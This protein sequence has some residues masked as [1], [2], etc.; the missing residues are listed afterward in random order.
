MIEGKPYP[1]NSTDQQ[2]KHCERWFENDGIHGHEPHCSW[3]GE[4]PP[5]YSCPCCDLWKPFHRLR[6]PK[7]GWGDEVDDEMADGIIV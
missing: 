4:D 6:C 1:I 7:G 3:K 2:C 5:L